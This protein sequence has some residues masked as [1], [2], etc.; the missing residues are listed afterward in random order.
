MDKVLK[1]KLKFVVSLKV[2]H[3]KGGNRSI[4]NRLAMDHFDKLT[5]RPQESV[6]YV[7]CGAGEEVVILAT[8]VRDVVGIDVDSAILEIAKR[9]FPADNVDYKLDDL[10]DASPNLLKWTG[11]FD[12]VV[13]IDRA[14]FFPKMDTVLRNMVGCLKPGGEM[15]AIISNNDFNFFD[16]AATIIEEHPEWGQSNKERNVT[17]WHKTEG[18]AEGFMREI[19]EWSQLSCKT[20]R[21]NFGL[22]EEKAKCKWSVHP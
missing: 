11:A 10:G 20:Q 14:M 3:S 16:G 19:C 9:D 7:G 1:S 22:S 17:L 5:C 21:L 12:K 6:L 4:C 15:L 18:E 2:R 8:R 13:S